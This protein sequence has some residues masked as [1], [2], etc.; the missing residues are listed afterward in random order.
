[1]NVI[2]DAPCR[3]PNVHSGYSGYG[4]LRNP[5]KSRKIPGF[6]NPDA[7]ISSTRTTPPNTTNSHPKI[8]PKT[9]IR[10]AIHQLE[11]NKSHGIAGIPGEVYKALKDWITTPLTKILQK[12][13][14]GD[15]LPPEWTQGTMV[16]ICKNKGNI[17]GRKNYRPICLT[18][19]SY[20]IRPIIETK[21]RKYFASWQTSINMDKNK[22]AQP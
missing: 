16:H 19:I 10:S 6:D 14:Q 22:A 17:R 9:D 11:N 2:Q 18:Q 7:I 4:R 8:C 21:T 3:T 5:E 15:Q 1:M 20:K 12:I 13:Q